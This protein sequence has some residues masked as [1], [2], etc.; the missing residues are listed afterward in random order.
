MEL[1]VLTVLL[2]KG[3]IT[4]NAFSALT[5]MAVITTLLAMPLARFGLRWD[6]GR[7]RSLATDPA[8]AGKIT[9]RPLD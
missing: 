4:P 1:V 8:I 6:A 2:D 5:L 3:I 7:S 9:A